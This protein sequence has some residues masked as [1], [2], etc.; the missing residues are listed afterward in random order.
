MA[1]TLPGECPH[2]GLKAAQRVVLDL[3]VIQR[4]ARG[5]LGKLRFPELA[6]VEEMLEGIACRL[7]FPSKFRGE[8]V[9]IVDRSQVE[10]G[11]EVFADNLPSFIE[12]ERGELNA[13]AVL[14]FKVTCGG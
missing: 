4:F 1:I 13:E 11:V 12:A 9:G 8:V 6:H 7:D 5:G 14:R 2:A 3:E 10:E